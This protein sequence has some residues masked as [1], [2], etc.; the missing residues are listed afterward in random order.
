MW[1]TD[2]KR[3]DL[4]LKMWRCDV[5]SRIHTLCWRYDVNKALLVQNVFAYFFWSTR[6]YC[7]SFGSCHVYP[8]DKRKIQIKFLSNFNKINSSEILRGFCVL[9]LFFVQSWATIPASPSVCLFVA[10]LAV[11]DVFNYF[12]YFFSLLLACSINASMMNLIAKQK[13]ALALFSYYYKD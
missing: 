13:I 8:K 6:P 9:L 2:A 3:I 7:N 12:W 4:A 1:T 5:I 10:L 11:L